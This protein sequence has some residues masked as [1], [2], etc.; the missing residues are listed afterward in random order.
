MPP[1]AMG[2]AAPTAENVDGAN[3]GGACGGCILAVSRSGVHTG[4]TGMAR[5]ADGG[6]ANIATGVAGV[7]AGLANRIASS[8]SDSKSAAGREEPF[9]GAR[10]ADVSYRTPAAVAGTTARFSLAIL[11]PFAFDVSVAALAF[12]L[13]LRVDDSVPPSAFLTVL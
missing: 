1:G 12:N 9:R 2:P 5:A 4:A 13:A 3:A 6:D 10:A 7:P 8:K 11:G